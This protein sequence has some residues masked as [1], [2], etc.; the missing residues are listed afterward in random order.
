MLQLGKEDELQEA[1]KSDRPEQQVVSPAHV[2]R[3]TFETENTQTR[4]YGASSVDSPR[5]YGL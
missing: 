4:V 1:S 3:T 5:K 2:G